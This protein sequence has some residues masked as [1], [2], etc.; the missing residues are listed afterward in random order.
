MARGVREPDLAIWDL[1]NS[2]T[3]SLPLPAHR[4]PV[5]QIRPA[6]AAVIDGYTGVGERDLASRDL[7]NSTASVVPMATQASPD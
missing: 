7:V 2:N 5:G 3:V 4:S 6:E 1:V